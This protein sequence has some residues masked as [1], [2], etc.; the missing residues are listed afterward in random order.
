MKAGVHCPKLYEL[1]ISGIEGREWDE[2]IYKPF[3]TK[4]HVD[5]AMRFWRYDDFALD[6]AL[7]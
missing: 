6:F 4:V 7:A 3:E 5:C 2:P 1:L